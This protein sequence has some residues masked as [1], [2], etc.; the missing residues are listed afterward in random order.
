MH[1]WKFRT[2]T[3]MTSDMLLFV[4]VLVVI[5]FAV[6]LCLHIGMRFLSREHVAFCWYPV[7]DFCL[8]CLSSEPRRIALHR[9]CVWRLWTCRLVRSSCLCSV[10]SNKQ[11]RVFQYKYSMYPGNIPPSSIIHQPVPS[12]HPPITKERWH[13]NPRPQQYH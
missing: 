2:L 3:C 7:L 9:T 1:I 5:Y 13:P 6:R 10:S 12:T 4:S 8:I 11:G